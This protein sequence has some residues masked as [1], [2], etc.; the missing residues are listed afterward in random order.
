[1]HRAGDQ[2]FPSLTHDAL[3]LLLCRC[4]LEWC[5]VDY[6]E[7]NALAIIHSCTIGQVHLLVCNICEIA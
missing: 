2:K 3:A 6:I 7:L 4:F 1:M 5:T